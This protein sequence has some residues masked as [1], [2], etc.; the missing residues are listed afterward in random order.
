MTNNYNTKMVEQCAIDTL[1]SKTAI[2]TISDIINAIMPFFQ[3]T[4]SLSL[5]VSQSTRF[6]TFKALCFCPSSDLVIV[7]ESKLSLTTLPGTCPVRNTVRRSA[8]GG[9]CTPSGRI[10]NA[11]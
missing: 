10:F 9:E 5:T 4:Q 7:K 6:D 3:P 1:V 2:I 8:V 11:P